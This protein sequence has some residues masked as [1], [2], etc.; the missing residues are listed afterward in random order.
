MR[1][2]EQSYE[3]ETPIGP[4]ILKQ[5][6]RA[7]RTCYKSE[8]RITENSATEFVAKLIKRK[9]HAMLE[10]GGA[11]TVRFVCDRGVSHEVVR[12]RL[13]SFAQE[14]TRFCNY[15]KDQFGSELTIIDISPHCTPEQYDIIVEA[16][17]A[18]EGFYFRLLNAGAPPEIARAVLMNILKTE[19]TVSGNTREW[20]HFFSQRAD[21][22]AHPQMRELAYPLLREFRG[23]VPGLFDDVGQV[24]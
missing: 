5:I 17:Q 16:A 11:I 14:S 8:D 18:S 15:L 12:H 6:E 20:R 7:G 22:L 21:E 4:E 23:R 1:I 2:V 3:I 10:F 9:H 24:E 13:F 19:V